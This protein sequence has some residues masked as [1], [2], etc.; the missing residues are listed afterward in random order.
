MGK[1]S[2]KC[3]EKR[4]KRKCR[5][6]PSGHLREEQM[7][8][9]EAAATQAGWRNRKEARAELGRGSRRGGYRAGSARPSGDVG[10][11]SV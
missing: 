10:P 1:T 8:T 6:Q 4:L 3:C 2:L 11:N 5:R 7:Q 9:P